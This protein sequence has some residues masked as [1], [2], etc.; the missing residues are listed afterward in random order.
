MISLQFPAQ[1]RRGGD[2]Q[3]GPALGSD[4]SST[5]TGLS[6]QVAS[7]SEV[8]LSWQP[9]SSATAYSV[10]RSTD[11]VHFTTIAN[12]ASS[13]GYQDVSVRAN[14]RYIYRVIASNAAGISSAS[15]PITV[16]TLA[17]GIT[18]I[19]AS[20][21]PMGPNTIAVAWQIPGRDAD[22][23]PD[24]AKDRRSLLDRPRHPSATAPTLT[25]TPQ[26]PTA[27]FA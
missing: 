27:L 17:T 2:P 10:Q 9:D 3:A 23:L 8:D 12:I 24:Y 25:M 13:S 6:A 15:S 21:A 19:N 14:T 26:P 5:P 4:G 22:R 11:G 18:A 7:S 20:A 16:T 1:R